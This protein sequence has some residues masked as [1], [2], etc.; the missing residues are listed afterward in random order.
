M[1]YTSVVAVGFEPGGQKIIPTADKIGGF[2]AR[3]TVNAGNPYTGSYSAKFGD[4]SGFKR[5]IPGQRDEIY[6][7]FFLDPAQIYS[8]T[9]NKSPWIRI[10]LENGGNFELAY[11][12]DND[13]LDLVDGDAQSGTETW[14]AGNYNHVQIHFVLGPAG[15]IHTKIN[16]TTDILYYGDTRDIGDTYITAIEFYHTG[17]NNSNYD[18]LDDLQVGYGGWP[19][20]LRAPYYVPIG[21]TPTQQFM[22]SVGSDAYVLVDEVGPN[23][24]DYIYADADGEQTIMTLGDWAETGKTPALVTLWGYGQKT[25]GNADKFA[26]ISQENGGINKTVHDQQSLLNASWS[27]INEIL[28]TAPDGSLWTEADI[29]NLEFG[30]E[31]EIV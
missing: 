1:S 19:G 8:F 30:F 3:C 27:Y 6:V 11:H 21:D 22:L 5:A 13:T 7:S 10:N 29:N 16:G 12:I 20:A 4:D 23:T 28:N 17:P 2:P 14:D 26:F 9:N 31:A 18:F 24:S 25:T 15:L